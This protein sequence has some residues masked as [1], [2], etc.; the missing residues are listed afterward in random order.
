MKKKPKNINVRILKTINSVY[1]S[2]YATPIIDIDSMNYD[3]TTL[4]LDSL[5]SVELIMFLE[6]EFDIAIDDA[7]A[8]EVMTKC[9]TPYEIKYALK[10]FGVIDIKE[11]RREKL[12][13][14]NG[15]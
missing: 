2:N 15:N 14:I 1:K 7:Y 8:E 10:K 11:E 4:E 3:L 5:D 6:N 13:N 12:K 9:K